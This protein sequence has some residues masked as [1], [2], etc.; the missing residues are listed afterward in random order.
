ME[1]LC[2]ILRG[3]EASEVYAAH[4]NFFFIVSLYRAGQSCILQ[5]VCMHTYGCT[6]TTWQFFLSRKHAITLFIQDCGAS[7]LPGRPT[8]WTSRPANGNYWFFSDSDA[9]PLLA[10][11][12]W[13][14]TDDCK[15]WGV[16]IITTL[17]FRYDILLVIF[18]VWE[19]V[20]NRRNMEADIPTRLVQSEGEW[21]FIVVA[22]LSKLANKWGKITTQHG[23]FCQQRS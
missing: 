2:K 12:W 1:L 10:S 6:S 5:S 23:P 3:R 18:R 16:D 15:R 8:E 13:L 20:G 14:Y 22:S 11:L 17:L 19:V 7:I 4:T 21:V 9:N